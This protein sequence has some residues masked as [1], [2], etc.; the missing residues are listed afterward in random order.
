MSFNPCIII[1]IYNHGGQIH[2]TIDSLRTSSNLPIFIIDDGSNEATKIALAALISNEPCIKLIRLPHNQGKGV[3]VIEG[4]ISAYNAG[5][6]HAI[7]IDADGQHD[8]KALPKLLSEAENHPTALISGI[9]N[10]DSSIPKARLYGRYI[11]HF[12]VWIETLSFDIKD[13]MCGFRVYPLASTV[14]LVKNCTIG[15]HM[16]FDTDI[17][18][19]LYWRGVKV[20]EHPVSVTYPP[21]GQSNFRTLEDN[22]LISWMHTRLVLGMLWRAPILLARKFKF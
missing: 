4:F 5:F 17:I 1:P 21:N 10:Y 9:P 8:T 6:S 7:Q 12:W 19:R 22:L 11:T 20:R 2:E 15:T 14:A 3:A 16:D 13:S 18:V